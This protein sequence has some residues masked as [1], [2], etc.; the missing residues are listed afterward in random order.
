ML[1]LKAIQTVRM[2]NVSVP[3]APPVMTNGTSK[4]DSEP[5]IARMK[6]QADDGPDRRQDDVPELVPPVGAVELG[7]LVD[8][9]R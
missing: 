6:R 9:A 8:L 5:E 1:R 2:T 3:L 4:T 7:R